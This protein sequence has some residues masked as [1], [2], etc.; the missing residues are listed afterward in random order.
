M[1][2]L[3]N[4]CHDWFWNKAFSFKLIKARY[5]VELKNNS[6]TNIKTFHT[7]NVKKRCVKNILNLTFFVLNDAFKKV[8]TITE[9]ICIFTSMRKCCQ[10]ISD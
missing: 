3:K 9:S 8:S 2:C 10:I 7:P 4:A 1:Y 5:S 6:H